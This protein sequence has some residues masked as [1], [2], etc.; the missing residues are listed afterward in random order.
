MRANCHMVHIQGSGIKVF[1]C[2][3]GLAFSVSGKNLEAVLYCHDKYNC[4]ALDAA[5]KAYIE[6]AE[7]QEAVDVAIKVFKASARFSLT[8]SYERCGQT[9]AKVLPILER[10][11]SSATYHTMIYVYAIWCDLC[12]IGPKHYSGQILAEHKAFIKRLKR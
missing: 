10:F 8:S 5:A 3:G 6:W 9:L 12:R 7:Q 4:G 11:V 1:L 2:A